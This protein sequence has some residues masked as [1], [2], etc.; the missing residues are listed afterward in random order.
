MDATRSSGLATDLNENLIRDTGL[1]AG[2]VDVK[3]CAVDETWS[4]LKFVRRLADR[5]KS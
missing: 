4:G 5:V 2:V 3:V 1:S